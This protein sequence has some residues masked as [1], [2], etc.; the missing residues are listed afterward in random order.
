MQVLMLRNVSEER[1]LSMKLYADRL[2]RGLGERCNVEAVYPWNPPYINRAGL[3]IIDKG[4]NYAA[5]YGVHP[6]SLLGR[7]AD[8]FHIVD[9]G[10]THLLSCLPSRRTVVTCHDIILLKLAKG[11]FGKHLSGPRWAPKLLKVSL[12][13][14]KSAAFVLADSQATADDLIKH[15]GVTCQQI[16][17]VP[18]GVDPQ[19]GMPPDGQSRREARA[20]WKVEDQTALLH[21]GN[22]WFYKNLEGLI[23]ALA[24]LQDEGIGNNP[25]L[26]KA[27]KKLTSEQRDLAASLGVSD[28]IREVGLLDSEELQSI[29]WASDVLVFPSLWEGFGWPPL[30]A[31]ASGTPVICSD[32]GSLSE[33]VGDSALIVNPERPEEIAEGVAKVVQNED[34]RQ[35]LIMKGLE[36]AKLF[37][38]E[39][40]AEQTFQVYQEVMDSSVKSL[41]LDKKVGQ[42]G[43]RT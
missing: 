31:M 13:F 36:R 5:R 8:V 39:R 7:R 30:E 29:Y 24:L 41:A 20:H 12:H 28:R 40:A 2:T 43:I 27:G 22:N 21:V 9:Q 34:L 19:F 11:E 42:P 38:W 16:R 26:L 3:G 4:M 32:R 14:L 6:A 18:L 33:V 15:A 10:N 1:N 17:V 23:R 25:V 35:S 37:S